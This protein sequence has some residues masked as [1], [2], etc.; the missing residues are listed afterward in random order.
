MICKFDFL[1]L[2]SQDLKM[3]LDDSQGKQ[4]LRVLLQMSMSKNPHL[5]LQA[6]KLIA[7]H[8]S[9]RS[10]LTKCFTQVN[11]NALLHVHTRIIMHV[12]VYVCTGSVVSIT[13]GEIELPTNSNKS[14]KVKNFS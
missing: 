7:R 1:L 11:C 9:Q 10:E 12:H 13:K 2:N 6:L 5:S 14:G 4:L 3:D 8:F